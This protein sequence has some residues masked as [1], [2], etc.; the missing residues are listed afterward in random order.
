MRI[1][2]SKQSEVAVR[3]QI[4]EQI[5]FLIA[6]EELKSGQTLPSVREL[7]RRLQ[8]HHTP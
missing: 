7:G 6:T 2:I 1:R 8:I 4:A 3:E 5:I